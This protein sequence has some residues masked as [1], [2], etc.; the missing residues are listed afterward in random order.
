MMTMTLHEIDSRLASILEYEPDEYVDTETGEMVC[1]DEVALLEME[2][3][4]KIEGWGLWI[5]NQYAMITALKAEE[6][7][8]KERRRRLERK[9]QNSQEAYQSYLDGEK[10]NTPRL[11]VSYRKVESVEID[12]AEKLPESMLRTKTI[13]EPDKVAIKAVLKTG[14]V[15]DGAHLVTRQSMTIK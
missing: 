5:K 7:N 1:A 14:K 12:D 8:L 6:D 9:V 10:V 15:I 2:R 13:V 11:S 3:S 4:D